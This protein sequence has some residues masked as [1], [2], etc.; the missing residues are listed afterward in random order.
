MTQPAQPA[1]IESTTL[2][3]LFRGALQKLHVEALLEGNIAALES[4]ELLMK[5][6]RAMFNSKSLPAAE[7]P[8][9]LVAQIPPGNSYL[10]RY[11]KK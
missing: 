2:Q 5:D 7:R 1:S 4:V 3:E 6:V 9:D 8:V 11:V 10:I